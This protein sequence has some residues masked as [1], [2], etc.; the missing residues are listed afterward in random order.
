MISALIGFPGLVAGAVLEGGLHPC[1]VAIALSGGTK[2]STGR[3]RK[4]AGGSGKAAAAAHVA[5]SWVRGPDG[6]IRENIT[7]SLADSWKGAW[8]MNDEK[9]G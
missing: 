7:S 6:M 4:G 1:K 3:G 9:D 2:R 8:V 5:R